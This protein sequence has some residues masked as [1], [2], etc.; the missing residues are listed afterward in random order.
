M[1]KKY[2][3]GIMLLIVLL[4]FYSAFADTKK[5][6]KLSSYEKKQT[7]LFPK[8]DLIDDADIVFRR[9]YGVDSTVAMN[10]SE[11]EKRYSHAGIIVKEGNKIYVLHSE[12]DEEKN[13]NGVFKETLHE[14]L[15][16][17]PVWAIYRFS[18]PK[19]IKKQIVKKC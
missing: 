2:I 16:N 19:K 6:E 14:F 4:I 10:F 13:Q 11:G 17:S 1:N 3:I 12:E 15:S 9:G 7:L 5:G 18:L 8:V